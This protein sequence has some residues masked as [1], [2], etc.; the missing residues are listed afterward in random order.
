MKHMAVLVLGC[1]LV[2]LALAACGGGTPK[3]TPAPAVVSTPAPTPDIEATVE[4]RLNEE[5]A[6]EA[7]VEARAQATVKAMVEATA[8]AVPKATPV[9]LSPT[10]TPS[11]TPTQTLTVTPV[12]PSSTPTLAPN[13]FIGNSQ[14]FGNSGSVSVSNFDLDDDDA[15]EQ[16][17]SQPSRPIPDKPKHPHLDSRLN[18]MVRQ[19]GSWSTADVA[20]SAPV[21]IGDLVGVTVRLSHNSSS[22]VD[23]LE[24]VGAIVA[25]IG[26]DYIEAYTPVTVLVS[27][28]ERDGV[29][30]V[31]A[32][33]PSEPAVTDN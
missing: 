2:M 17:T 8:Q 1:L 19:I 26:T 4:A 12:S 9:P 10:S 5:R 25:N 30:R 14:S 13:M 11:L 33:I 23:F 22:T 6:I 21:S 16:P 31:E 18:K 3:P 15:P 7:T 32:I 24:S 27:L 28:S 20:S 29:L